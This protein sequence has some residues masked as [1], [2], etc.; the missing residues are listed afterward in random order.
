M[1]PTVSVFLDGAEGEKF[2]LLREFAV[3]THRVETGD[4]LDL[5]R[6]IRLAMDGF[7]FLLI[8]FEVLTVSLGLSPHFFLCLLVGST[9]L[10]LLAADVLNFNHVCHA[11]I[12]SFFKEASLVL[13]LD[14]HVRTEPRHLE[15]V[16]L[17]LTNDLTDT[18]VLWHFLIGF[19][20]KLRNNVAFIIEFLFRFSLLAFCEWLVLLE[21]FVSHTLIRFK[22]LINE[23]LMFRVGV[24]EMDVVGGGFVQMSFVVVVFLNR[25]KRLNNF[26]D[27]DGSGVC[28][29]LQ[30]VVEKL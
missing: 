23:E 15:E 3:L 21:H 7:P 27:V 14:R 28:A 8:S 9:I 25:F 29:H 2:L 24:A 5:A 6:L 12:V 13:K 16:N 22:D 1:L 30:V 26:A 4:E 20:L 19:K 18:D 10:I 17:G 11:S